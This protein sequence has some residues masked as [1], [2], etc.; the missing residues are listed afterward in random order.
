MLASHL[1]YYGKFYG[2]PT[3]CIQEFKEY[4]EEAKE[5]TNEQRQAC[6]NGF[7]PCHEHSLQILSGTVKIEDLI[8][9]TRKCPKPYKPE[10]RMAKQKKVR[11]LKPNSC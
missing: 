10:S 2:F 5:R 8:L 1:E 3:C 4:F 11:V 6:S 9:P 7:V